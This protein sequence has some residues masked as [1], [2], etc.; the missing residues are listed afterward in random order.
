MT[1]PRVC[2][3][4]WRKGGFHRRKRCSFSRVRK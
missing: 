3:N 2:R 1:R 4:D